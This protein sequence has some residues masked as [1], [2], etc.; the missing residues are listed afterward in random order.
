MA[1]VELS[2]FSKHSSSTP[3]RHQHRS[4]V[5]RRTRVGISFAE[6]CEFCFLWQLEGVLRG[7]GMAQ[8]ILKRVGHEHVVVEFLGHLLEQIVI[9]VPVDVFVDPW[10]QRNQLAELFLDSCEVAVHGMEFLPEL[11]LQPEDMIVARR[12]AIEESPGNVSLG[13]PIG[14]SRADQF[15]LDFTIHCFPFSMM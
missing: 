7:D 6:F 15:T 8:E 11:R 5:Y 14:K 10:K 1:A 9:T 12:F 3:F 13:L 2:T 4:C